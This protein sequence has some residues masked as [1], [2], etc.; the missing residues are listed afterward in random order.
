LGEIDAPKTLKVLQS[1]NFFIGFND[2][3]HLSEKGHEI[4]AG[5][6]TRIIKEKYL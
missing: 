3:L 6:L 4:M 5:F 1:Y 2:G